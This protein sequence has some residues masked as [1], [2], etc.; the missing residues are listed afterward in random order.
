M[1][2]VSE[3]LWLLH[4]SSRLETQTSFSKRRNRGPRDVCFVRVSLLTVKDSGIHVYVE[5]PSK[6]GAALRLE[7]YKRVEFS[8]VT[9]V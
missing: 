2:I 3:A 4:F 7:V 5:V 8:R 9:E 6:G 1:V